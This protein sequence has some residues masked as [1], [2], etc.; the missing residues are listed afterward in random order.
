MADF[1][2][3]SLSSDPHAFFAGFD[4]IVLVAN[5]RDAASVL[6]APGFGARPLFVFF[7]RVYRILDQPAVRDCIL[8]SRS[9]PVGA[10]LVY[11][12]EL[13]DVMSLVQGPRFHGIL[14]VRARDKE[15]LSPVEDFKG[16]PIGFLDLVDLARRFYPAGRRMPSTG[17]AFALWLAQQKLPIP[18]HLAGFS[19]VREAQWRV[20]DAH[21]WTWEQIVLNIMFKKKLL[22]PFL[23]GE[24]FDRWPVEALTA[25][26]PDITPA[27][28][29][30]TSNEVLSHRLSGT[31]RVID[32]IYSALRFQLAIRDLMRRLRPR[33]RKQRTRDKLL[34][35]Q[36]KA[37]GNAA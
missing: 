19:G 4:S 34:A 16:H 7:N 3:S 2:I 21:D 36:S 26:F 14:N 9:S 24:Y 5:S 29:S 33:S 30:I 23:T 13:D 28:F 18:I 31:N 20:F 25:E 11:R 37:G 12:R 22:H 1:P 10:S 17:F 32:H 15:M 8:I 27:E 6:T 35:E